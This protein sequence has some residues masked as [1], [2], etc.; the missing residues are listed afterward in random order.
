MEGV[1]NGA[2]P[3]VPGQ[4]VEEVFK[5]W[6]PAESPFPEKFPTDLCPSGTFC[7]II[8]YISFM[9][10]LDAFQTDVSVLDL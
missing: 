3:P 7:Q 9:Y 6:K 5:K 1:R 2:P 4:Q 8:Q 10:G